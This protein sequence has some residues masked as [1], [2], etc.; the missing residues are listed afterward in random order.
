MRALRTGYNFVEPAK[1]RRW[2]TGP[3]I[4][5]YTRRGFGTIFFE[6]CKHEPRCDVELD[7]E[8]AMKIAAVCAK[9][10]VCG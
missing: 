10:R 3:R 4:V 5:K 2:S 7:E 1:L 9:V 8:M 6:V